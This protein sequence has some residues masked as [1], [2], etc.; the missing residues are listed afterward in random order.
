LWQT[1]FVPKANL[2]PVPGTQPFQEFECSVC[3]TKFAGISGAS[4]I[5]NMEA[6][7]AFKASMFKKWGDHL[8]TAH[9]R[10]WEA[11]QKKKAKFEAA[12]QAKVYGK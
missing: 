1:V 7:G 11:E 12:M 2:R 4:D 8:H 9:R 3:K 5:S 10:Q 6:A